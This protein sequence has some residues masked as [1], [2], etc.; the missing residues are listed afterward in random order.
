[1]APFLGCD[2][3]DRLLQ[4]L[5]SILLLKLHVN[6]H[7]PSEMISTPTCLGRLAFRSLSQK[8]FIASCDLIVT[9][10]NSPSPT[11]LLLQESLEYL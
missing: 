1:M 9:L 10:F 5:F 2:P 3:N 7:F 11:S 6:H 4:P 8:Q